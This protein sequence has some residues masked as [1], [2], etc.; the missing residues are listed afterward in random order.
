M[1]FRFADHLLLRLPAYPAETNYKDPRTLLSDPFFRASVYLASPQFFNRLAECNFN[2]EDLTKKEQATVLK[3]INRCSFR[4]TPF[5]LFACV[6]LVHW[7]KPGAIVTDHKSVTGILMPD[8]AF[9][10][11]AGQKLLDM[12]AADK[13]YLTNPTIYRVLREY[14]FISTEIDENEK[15][16]YQLQSTDYSIVLRDLLRFCQKPRLPDDIIGQIGKLANTGREESDDYFQFL[17]DSQVIVPELRANITG[18]NYLAVLLGAVKKKKE[19]FNDH[20]VAE[21]PLNKLS[22]ESIVNYKSHLQQL[23]GNHHPVS[24]EQPVSCIMLRQHRDAEL[25]VQ[26]KDIIREGLYALNCL[27][28]PDELPALRK[29]ISAFREDFEGQRVPLL[30]ALDPERGIGYEL[31]NAESPNPLL[32]TLNIYPA[33]SKDSQGIWTPAHAY[34]MERWITCERNIDATI[35]LEDHGLKQLSSGDELQVTLGLSVLFRVTGHKVFLESV[36]G[37]NVLAL[38][39]RFTVADAGIADA[40]KVMAAEQELMN[41]ELIFA[42]LL[43]MT[44]P[45]IDNVNRRAHLWSYEIPLTAS[46]R[47]PAE[48][49]LNLNE[50]FLEVHN[51]QIH[52]WSSRHRRYV[53]PRLSTAYNHSINKLPVFRFLADLPYQFGRNNLT[54]SLRQYFPGLSYY[55]RVE[56]GKAILSPATWMISQAILTT[57]QEAQENELFPLFKQTADTLNLPEIFAINDGDQQLIFNRY[58]GSD[59]SLFKEV[60]RQRKELIITE[61][62]QHPGV[63][64]VVADGKGNAFFHQFNAFILP[65]QPLPLPEPLEIATPSRHTVRK[66]MPGSEWLYLKIYCPKLNASKLLLKI[67]PLIRRK[68][69][70]GR[71]NK[72]FFIRYEDHAPHIRLRLKIDP[73]DVSE[74]LMSFRKLLEGHIDQHVIREY[75]VDTYSRE[76]ERYHAAGMEVTEDLFWSSS[77]FV[78]QF[79]RKGRHQTAIPAY[80]AALASVQLLIAELLPDESEQKDFLYKCYEKMAAGFSHREAK[81]QL[82]LRYRELSKEINQTLLDPHYLSTHRLGAVAE[83]LRQHTAK[84]RKALTATE[85]DWS[86]YLHSILHMHINRMFT[87]QQPRQEMVI[88]YLLYKFHVSQE[89]RKKQNR[90]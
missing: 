61:C 83:E 25:D 9:V 7:G 28:P 67:W 13:K 14:R 60:I 57:F 52:L 38:L 34:L 1:S 12:L 71:S 76:L 37:N 88:Y 10:Y 51:D 17:A 42:E 69:Q 3:Y 4:P 5:G 39:G 33:S 44:D 66:Y 62:I 68:Y 11:K 23:S 53:I 43:H 16:S 21:L 84:I 80:L 70:H 26:F 55:P 90:N 59:I 65:D 8:E 77:M 32:E 29:F 18:E 75:Q 30:Q 15:R 35:Q 89:G 40:A 63:K 64:A 74:I 86:D 27:C 73:R 85:A 24:A 72:W 58:N 87:D 41:S 20:T 45:H 36:G 81:R 78:L 22:V 2:F 31:P 79:L 50:L 46:S 47:L 19:I 56:Y 49:Q 82:D 6:S 54:F 48:R